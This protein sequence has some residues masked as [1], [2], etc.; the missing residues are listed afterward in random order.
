[1]GAVL[2]MNI[3]FRT[4]AGLG[5]LALLAACGTGRSELTPLFSGLI[6]SYTS[7]AEPQPDV[8]GMLTRQLLSTSDAPLLLIEAPRL[9]STATLRITGRNG[10]YTTW[11]TG[12]ARSFTFRGGVLSATRGLGDDL[13]SADNTAAAA[14]VAA[15]NAG[16]AP[17]TQYYL[18]AENQIYAVRFNCTFQNAGRE[19][20]EIVERLHPTVRLRETC[21]NEGLA[22]QN[23]Y[24]VGSDGMV[25]KSRQWVG[26]AIG[27]IVTERL[28]R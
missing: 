24:W 25:W 16:D 7:P 10:P 5:G 3:R 9:A 2:E 28:I 18:D 11:T 21:R 27:Y 23:D 4:W 15:R 1:M 19:T 26:P 13:S 20:I 6:T 17:R 14:R 8:R 12:D 22:I